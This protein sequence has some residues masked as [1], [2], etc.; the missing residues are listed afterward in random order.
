MI[1]KNSKLRLVLTAFTATLLTVALLC[2]PSV[3]AQDSTS[4]LFINCALYTAGQKNFPEGALG[5]RNGEITYA[6]RAAAAPNQG[7]ERVV[8][9]KGK[10]IYPA[11]IAANT[12]L[13]L[14][15]IFAVRATNDY[16]ESGN[17][18]PNVRALPAYNA[19]SD[20]TATVRANGVLFAQICPRGGVLSGTSS[21]VV[22]DGLNWEDAAYHTDEGLHMNW[23]RMYQ[24]AGD[25]D[26]PEAYK[27]NEH[28]IKN[29]REIREFF[30]KARAYAELEIP[31]EHDLRLEALRGIFTGEKRLYIH[32]D[33][34]KEIRE[35]TLFKNDFNL[36][37]VTLVGGY[38]AWMAA[39]LLRENNVS[40]M[41]RRVNSLP[42]FAEDPI[43]ASFV[44]P[45]QLAA[46]EVDFCFQ[47]AGSMEAMQNRNIAFNAGTA[48]GYGLDKDV[49]L[50]ALT[51]K[52]AEILG[53]DGQTG[54][55]EQGKEANFIVTTGDLFDIRSSKVEEMYFRGRP[56]N[57]ETKQE[58][59]YRKFSTT[60]PKP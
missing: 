25:D 40:V 21:A 36:P 12:T 29:L 37:K 38:D 10:H 57:L 51:L 59:L 53:I 35:I 33:F 20:I 14:T 11:L 49:A 3:T 9:L 4:V 19:E 48:I 2:S 31:L 24:P 56:I 7:Y 46:A 30:E 52:P 13:G 32:A 15:E 42:R 27:A 47:M 1:L 44:L 17:M 45:A 50:K 6:G 55:L 5:I 18:N 28:Y 58:Q 23:P 60:G 54:S 16:R 8:D 39:D 41:V 22:L 26:D 43:D 34:I